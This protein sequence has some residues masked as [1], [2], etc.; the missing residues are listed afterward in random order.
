MCSVTRSSP[1]HS[2]N[3]T[4]ETVVTSSATSKGMSV[5]NYVVNTRDHIKRNCLVLH[6]K[7]ILKNSEPKHREPI[8]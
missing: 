6:W 8:I 3:T 1:L 2:G 4:V 7:K 5:K